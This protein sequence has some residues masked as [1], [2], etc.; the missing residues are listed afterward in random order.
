M[1]TGNEFSA[2]HITAAARVSLNDTNDAGIER[3]DSVP[4]DDAELR[5]RDGGCATQQ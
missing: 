5:L 4:V 1:P 3:I 2:A